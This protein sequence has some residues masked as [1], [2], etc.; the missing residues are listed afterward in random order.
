MNRL[1]KAAA[2]GVMM[3]KRAAEVP[4]STTP[5]G[6]TE[7]GGRSAIHESSLNPNQKDNTYFAPNSSGVDSGAGVFRANTHGG[8]HPYSLF[9]PTQGAVKTD[10]AY[11]N[12]SGVNPSTAISSACNADGTGCPT[13]YANMFKVNNPEGTKLNLN[14]VVMT[15]PGHTGAANIANS[16]P[17]VTSVGTP[18]ATDMRRKLI[19][20]P[21]SSLHD[22]RLAKGGDPHNNAHWTDTG[23]YTDGRK[24]PIP[25]IGAHGEILEM[26]R[27]FNLSPE[28]GGGGAKSY[29]NKVRAVNTNPDNSYSDKVQGNFA[30]P[31]GSAAEF[32]RSIGNI[33]GSVKSNSQLSLMNARQKQQAA[34]INAQKTQ[35]P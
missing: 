30:R 9:N 12:L 3:G 27:H 20:G 11:P 33:A 13:S 19:G 32:A 15:P 31:M 16:I 2:F 1:E 29:L 14:K 10:T 17:G 5:S 21:S 22:Y 34:K 8:G 23:T 28:L 18:Y 25:L 6:S 4:V 7:L 26:A 24:S 35:Q